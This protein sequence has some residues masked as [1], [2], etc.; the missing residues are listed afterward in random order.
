MTGSPY[1]INHQ[2]A[3]AT[4]RLVDKNGDGVASK[5]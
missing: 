3:M 1:R 2:Q 4:M 5:A